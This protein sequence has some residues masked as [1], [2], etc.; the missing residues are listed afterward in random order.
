M[1]Q[2]EELKKLETGKLL[3]ELNEARKSLFKIRFEVEN[4]QAKNHHEIKN[5]KTY[6]A[7]IKTILKEQEKSIT[8]KPSD[9]EN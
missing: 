6:I 3:E 8:N 9:N 1:K 7:R 2:L 5:Y 4:G